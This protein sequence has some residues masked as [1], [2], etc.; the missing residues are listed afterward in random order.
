MKNLEIG[1]SYTEILSELH[2]T[3]DL[4]V[5][6]AGHG[7]D[8]QELSTKF[9]ELVAFYCSN[10]LTETRNYIE[11]AKIQ[12]MRSLFPYFF[13]VM[14]N[15]FL[16]KVVPHYTLTKPLVI[17]YG[18]VL[19]SKNILKRGQIQRSKKTVPPVYCQNILDTTIVPFDKLESDYNIVTKSVEIRF[20]GNSPF[21]LGSDSFDLWINYG[22]NTSESTF[23]YSLFNRKAYGKLKVRYVD[24][25][26]R[27]FKVKPEF[28]CDYKLHPNFNVK[29]LLNSPEFFLKIRLNILKLQNML[30]KVKDITLSLHADPIIQKHNL[31]KAFHVNYLP[32]I[33]VQRE[34]AQ[35]IEYDSTKDSYPLLHPVSDSFFPYFVRSVVY[36]SESQGGR[37]LPEILSPRKTES[38]YKIISKSNLLGKRYDHLALNLPEESMKSNV[39]VLA[40]WTQLNEYNLNWMEFSFYNKQVGAFAFDNILYHRFIKPTSSNYSGN[41]LGLLKLH[42]T[43]VLQLEDFKLLLQILVSKDSALR[44]L[45]YDF[46]ELHILCNDKSCCIYELIFRESEAQDHAMIELM[47]DGLERFLKSNLGFEKEVTCKVRFKAAQKDDSNDN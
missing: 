11:E 38:S 36:D 37:V 29:L 7:I 8:L 44:Q 21:L 45:T 17:N 43:S 46:L 26:V 20:R 30:K 47:V 19:T 3:L 28:I 13:S 6:R 5:A 14:P 39:S 4:P 12:R 31:Q 35:V 42:N 34:Y 23:L 22:Q 24:N 40:E 18:E 32:I 27:I 33:N 10:T 9:L 2:S 25:K 41:I 15:R 16:L 1:K